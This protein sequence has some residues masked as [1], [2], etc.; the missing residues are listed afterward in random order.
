[1]N[2]NTLQII[3]IL[4]FLFFLKN[5]SGQK[6]IQLDKET[7]EFMD[8]I[9]DSALKI[10]SWSNNPYFSPI[11]NAALFTLPVFRYYWKSPRDIRLTE[12]E[13]NA[14]F[15]KIKDSSRYLLTQDQ[16][17]RGNKYGN[18]TGYYYHQLQIL[19]YKIQHYLIGDQESIPPYCLKKLNIDSTLFQIKTYQAVASDI[20]RYNLLVDS[21]KKYI[22]KEIEASSYQFSKP[23]FLRKG[24]LCIFIYSYQAQGHIDIYLKDKT[25]WRLL[26]NMVKFQAEMGWSE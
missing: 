24:H 3:L 14:I 15:E 22:D 9:R 18:L 19:K 20:K 25:G 1:M 7:I 2:K 13:L 11:P 12:Q 16:L 8:Y 6:A 4:L 21:C 17:K 26:Q 5:V 10:D 23:I